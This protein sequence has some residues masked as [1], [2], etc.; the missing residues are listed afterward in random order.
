MW[1][2]R[3]GPGGPAAEVST[4]SAKTL[5]FPV[6]RSMGDVLIRPENSPLDEPWTDYK[7]ARGTVRVPPGM[8]VR[9]KVS[10]SSSIDLRPLAEL[11]YDDLQEIDARDTQADDAQLQHL[12]GLTSLRALGLGA[13]ATSDEGLA[14]LASFH[15]LR[16]LYL[17]RT[18]IRGFGL[19]AL[20]EANQLRRLALNN[21]QVGD[22]ALDSLQWLL[23]LERLWLKNTRVTDAGLEK[24]RRLTH[25]RLLDLR[26]TDVTEAGVSRLKRV[27]AGCQVQF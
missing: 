5:R 23:S 2:T 13:T 20:A 1:F 22:H 8:E 24:L 16:E 21:T 17:P 26:G 18:R 9:L 14:F 25:V 10:W 11:Q 27:N 6:H 12:A 7:D 15:G 19:R 3:V 4:D